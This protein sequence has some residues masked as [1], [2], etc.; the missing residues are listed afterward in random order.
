MSLCGSILASKVETRRDII[1]VR[2]GVHKGDLGVQRACACQGP[3]Q[4]QIEAAIGK[5]TAGYQFL[6]VL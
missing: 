3:L 2:D 6:L 1:Y 5:I 4:R